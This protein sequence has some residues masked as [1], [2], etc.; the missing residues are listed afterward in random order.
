MARSKKD[1]VLTAENDISDEVMPVEEPKVEIVAESAPDVVKT[2]DEGVAELKKR[3]EVSEEAQRKL[4]RERNEAVKRAHAAKTEVRETNDLLF[5]KSQADITEQNKYL[6][7]QY[8]FAL[9][10]QDYAAAADI[11]EA[12]ALNQAKSLQIQNGKQALKEE[13]P[14]D[15]VEALASQLS[16][17]SAAWVRAHPEFA[18][19]DRLTRKM[20]AA[21][22]LAL[23]DGHAAD[24]DGYFDSVEDTLKIAQRAPTRAIQDDDGDE[25]FS[26]ASRPTSG[27]QTAPSAIPVSRDVSTSGTR[28]R[29]IR[30]SAA[31]AEAAEMSGISHEE[32]ARNR[33]SYRAERGRMN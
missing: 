9:Q 32:Y 12:L 16:P 3:L 28:Q 5:N 24:T 18:T 14:L 6:K 25:R 22:N 8:A 2:A 29:T 31:E 33:D 11:Q 1:A 13:P 20:I 15:P 27:R 19:N 17:R 10:N 4:E 23:A 26:D 7:S 21:H 30:L